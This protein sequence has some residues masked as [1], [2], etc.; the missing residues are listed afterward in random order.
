MIQLYRFNILYILLIFIW[1]S[2]QI[3]LLKGFDGAGRINFILT[4]AILLLNLLNFKNIRRVFAQN[5]ILKI[6][7]VALIYKI[8]NSYFLY[9]PM[10]TKIPLDV[11]IISRLVVPFALIL[12]ISLIPKKHINIFLLLMIGTLYFSGILFMIG[13]S[14]DEGK[15]SNK[16]FN[17]NELVLVLIALIAFI[18]LYAIRVRLSSYLLILLLIFPTIFIL[19][20]GSRMGFGAYLILVLGYWFIVQDK[21]SINFIFKMVFIGLVCYVSFQ[22]I[23]ENTVV[24]K[25]L[26]STTEDSMNIKESRLV[27]GTVFEKFGDRGIFYIKGWALFVQNPVC[28]IGLLNFNKSNYFVCHVEYIIHLCELG[29]IGFLFYILFLRALWINIRKRIRYKDNVEAHF[30]FCIL[31]CILFSAMVL[32]LYNSYAIAAL[33]GVITLLTLNVKKKNA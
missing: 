30:L 19:Y 33:F 13:S 18:I 4:C 20:S 6:A 17:I 27:Q 8:I 10:H 24:G 16:M 23:T 14:F 2:I 21:K 9:D 31:I 11:F 28:G 1:Q 7:L 3:N 15:F 12:T 32:F 5:A 29:I 26:M 22:Y 25:R